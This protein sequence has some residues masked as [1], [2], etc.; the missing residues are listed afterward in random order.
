MNLLRNPTN[1]TA[2]ARIEMG[3][4]A[5]SQPKLQN[6]IVTSKYTLLTFLPMNFLHQIS[7]GS[8]FFFFVT[9]ILMCTPKISPFEPYTYILAFCIIVGISMVKDAMEDYKRH[10]DDDIINKSKVKIVKLVK[11]SNKKTEFEINEKYCMELSPGDFILAEKD[12]EIQADVVLLSAKK[13]H[14]N[15]LVCSNNCYIETSNIDGESNLKKRHAISSKKCS[16]TPTNVYEPCSCAENYFL[17]IKS[18]ELK[19]T[20]DSFNEFECDFDLDGKLVIANTKNTLLRGSILKNT[21]NALCF[22]VGVGDQTKQSKSVH[23]NKKSKTL[24]DNCTNR[25][26]IVVLLLYAAILIITSLVGSIFLIS[27]SSNIYLNI[28]GIGMPIVK[29]IFSNYVLYTYLIP[30]SLYVILEVARFIHGLYILHDI[31]MI[32][33]D[34]KRSTCRN[35]NAIED[36]GVIDYILSDKTGTLTKNSM[37]LKHIH[38]MNSNQLITADDLC[39]EIG[40]ILKDSTGNINMNI[41]KSVIKE[42]SPNRNKLLLILTMLICNTVEILNGKTEG[43]SQEELCFLYSIAKNG[44]TLIE[45]DES[46]V[47]IKLIN[48]TFKANI[49]GTLD[50]TSKRQRMGVIIEILDKIFLLEKGSDLKLLDKS[51]DSEILKIINSS[52]DYRCLVMKYRELTP[53]MAYKFKEHSDIEMQMDKGNIEVDLQSS[54][55][56]L[57]IKSQLVEA[58]FEDLEKESIYI[59][60]TFIEDKLQGNVQETIKILKE[61][62]IKVWMIT[63][64]KKETAVACA[65][66]AC[67]VEDQNLVVID[68][69]NVLKMMEDDIKN[70]GMGN[71]S[72]ERPINIFNA[73]GV[74]VYRATPSQKGKIASFLVKAGKNTLSIGDGNN[75]VGML[76]ESH[77]GV[78][79]MGKEGTQAAL[80]ADFAIP[81]FC[82]LRNLILI[83]G[84]YSFIRYTKLALNSYYKNIVF[85]FVQ[86]LY[87]LYC[88]ASASPLYNSFTLNYYNLFFTSMI[89]LSIVL[90]DRDV[91]PGLALEQPSSYRHIRNHFHKS[92][93]FLNVGFAIFEAIVIFY[94]IKL[95]TLNDITNGSGILGT[96]ASIS[97]IFSIIVIFTVV[98]R[99]IRM[100]SF[101][102]IYTDIAIALTV[103]LNII[104]IFGIQELYNK[105][106]YVIY[107]LL[108]MPNFYYICISLFTLIYSIDTIFENCCIYLENRLK[109]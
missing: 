24:F 85:I 44:Y 14:K 9:L 105:S 12:L 48:Q 27:N 107:Y 73:S 74:V 33:H 54:N 69:Q 53:E 34:E 82:F 21:E 108:T 36:L 25:I 67:I 77:I 15:K 91:P 109:K 101:R 94:C 87:N 6:K 22:V 45:R 47:V 99:Q 66:N 55:N 46:Y 39:T 52:H 18:F 17:N 38:E 76:K 1:Q 3:N 95:F 37:T 43:I 7:K 59:G 57:K 29:L 86:F 8:T 41:L 50:F 11:N 78:G 88:G 13:F 63:G 72:G 42:N 16:I 60:S 5:E 98:L 79:I 71:I 62:N 92:Y 84:R 2:G 75:D 83:H 23:K 32:S 90:F 10:K 31:D 102:V 61:A 65:K 49:I 20:G 81:E 19:D 35:L 58:N 80:S 93:V 28:S 89:P 51:K 26:L 103:I 104:S 100:V 96:Y 64:D 30:L 40:V 68:G 70:E 106:N 4:D 97:T 56:L